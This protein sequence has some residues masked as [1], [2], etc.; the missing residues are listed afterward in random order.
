MSIVWVSTCFHFI[1][2]GIIIEDKIRHI[3]LATII[4]VHIICTKINTTFS[5]A[6]CSSLIRSLQLFSA[7]A[8]FCRASWSLHWH[9][10]NI[11]GNGASSCNFSWSWL[12]QFNNKSEQSIYLEYIRTLTYCEFKQTWNISA[13]FVKLIFHLIY[14]KERNYNKSNYNF[15]N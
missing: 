1:V 9:A 11:S 4:S 15:F 10:F 12:C 14:V 6:S 13:Y 5:F 8:R 2:T 7:C 3:H